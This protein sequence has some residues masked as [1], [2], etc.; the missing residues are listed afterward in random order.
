MYKE[1]DTQRHTHFP[2]NVF[3]APRKSPS[4]KPKLDN[5]PSSVVYL[6][7]EGGLQSEVSRQI[8]ERGGG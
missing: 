2:K 6:E 1:T 5:S 8:E 4:S 3:I 7:K